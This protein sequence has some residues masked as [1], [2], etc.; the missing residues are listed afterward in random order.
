M[1]AAKGDLQRVRDVDVAKSVETEMLTNI[2]LVATCQPLVWNYGRISRCHLGLY[3]CGALRRWQRCWCRFDC[4]GKTE[5]VD[6]GTSE[7]RGNILLRDL[8]SP[9]EMLAAAIPRFSFGVPTQYH[10]KDKGCTFPSP[11]KK[12]ITSESTQRRLA[13]VLRHLATG[14]TLAHGNAKTHVSASLQHTLVKL[15]HVFLLGANRAPT[16][17]D[18]ICTLCLL[19]GIALLKYFG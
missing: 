5:A 10:L 18:M 1:H 8:D 11:P 14:A 13:H 3:E 17:D 2:W 4:R 16:N 6:T 9:G 12:V 7:W 19:G 15:Q